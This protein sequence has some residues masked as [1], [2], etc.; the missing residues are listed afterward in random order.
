MAQAMIKVTGL[1]NELGA[2]AFQPAL[3]AWPILPAP[4]D[5]GG[6]G[7]PQGIARRPV[8]GVTPAATLPLVRRALCGR[9]ARLLRHSQTRRRPPRAAARFD[10]HAAN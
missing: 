9:R 6:I 1:L 8:H 2:G 4:A 7:D 10:N 5:G 3:P